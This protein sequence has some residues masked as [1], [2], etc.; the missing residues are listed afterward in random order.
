MES[1]RPRPY[2]VCRVLLTGAAAFALVAC[3][4]ATTPQPGETS[5]ASGPVRPV[6]SQ[7]VEADGALQCPESVAAAAVDKPVPVPQKPQGVDGAARLLPDRDPTSLVVCA[8]P[9]VD[10]MK[11]IQPPFR[12]A[13]RT[14]ASD[15]QR[16]ELVEALTWSPRDSG[17]RRVCTL[18]AG[19]ETAYVVGASYGDAVVWVSALADANACST[20]TNG[21]F[22][23]GPGPAV[24]L[25]RMFGTRTPP[26]ADVVAC[27]RTSWGR[28]GD[29]RSLAPEGDPTATVCRDAADGTV[30]A[31][32]LDA[33]QS[34]EV[35]AALRALPTRPTGQ[36]CQG[37][38]NPGN[39]RF[40]LLLTYAVGP[41]VRLTVD[42]DCA[43][44][45]LGTNLES[46][47]AS[48]LVELVEQWSPRIPGPDLNGSVSS[49]GTVVPPAPD[50]TAPAE[51]PGSTGGGGAGTGIEP[52]TPTEIPMTK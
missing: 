18:M 41:P 11:P 19:N 30:K 51:V 1:R 52:A 13:K 22:R 44:A 33:T 12:L 7:P 17:A 8:Y 21:D 28:L 47:D 37:R 43:P 38:D 5:L 31:T 27:N 23:S 42:P 10:I 45:V 14:V 49:D 50:A 24:V 29:D 20:S 2:A 4:T 39:G 34:A 6:T 26:S 9:V 16:V 35:V 3:G 25:E 36:T 48:S 46:A 40:T 32:P 15:G